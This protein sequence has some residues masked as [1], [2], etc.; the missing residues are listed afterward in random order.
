MALRPNSQCLVCRTVKREPK[1]GRR[2][3]LSKMFIPGGESLLAISR[4]YEGVFM[5]KSLYTHA[6]RHQAPTK[7]KLEKRIKQ[8]ETREA[9]KE[10]QTEVTLEKTKL[11]INHNEG[12]RSMLER[13]MEALEAGDMK[14]SAAVM[15]KLLKD[16][17]DIEEKSK[18][19][20]LELMKM[21]QHFVASGA[22]PIPESTI[23]A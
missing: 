15:A 17:S 9:A 22:R 10:I 14:M 6:H 21:V 16:E 2:I 20:S 8:F 12:R 7:A 4:D 18:D 13:G 11:Y 23:D 5:A 3:E 19:R 1:L